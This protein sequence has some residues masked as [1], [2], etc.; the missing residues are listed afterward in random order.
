MNS[1]EANILDIF[2]VDYKSYYRSYATELR[3]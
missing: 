1:F 3:G 2:D